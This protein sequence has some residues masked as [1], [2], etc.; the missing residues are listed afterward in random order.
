[1]HLSTVCMCPFMEGASLLETH[2]HVY[3][4]MNTSIMYTCNHIFGLSYPP[5]LHQSFMVEI[6]RSL[7]SVRVGWLMNS[8]Q[9]DCI[10]VFCWILFSTYYAGK[11]ISTDV[12]QEWFQKMLP[13]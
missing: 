8:M 7:N 4:I 13:K 1:M 10:L 11:S 6:Q 2:F 12:L 9:L 5:L 3:F